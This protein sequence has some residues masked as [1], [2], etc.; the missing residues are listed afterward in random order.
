MATIHERKNKTGQV[1]YT[2]EIR[3]KGHPPQSATFERKT[4]AKLWAQKTEADIRAGKHFGITESKK[5]TV[6]DMVDRYIQDILPHRRSDAANVKRHLEWWKS[7]LGHYRL[8]DLKPPLIAEYRDRLLSE[9]SPKA[10][11]EEEKRSAATVVRYLTSLSVAV[12][13]AVKEWGWMEENPVLKVRKPA[14]PRGRVRFLTDDEREAVLKACK[15]SDSNYLYTIVVLALS[16][17]AR[18]SEILNLQWQHVDLKRKAILLEETKNG[19]RRSLPLSGHGLELVKELRKVPRIDSPYVF[20]RKDGRK[21][22]EIRKKWERAIKE[23]KVKDFRFHDLRHT[24]ASYL[25]MQGASLLEISAVLGHKTLSMVKRYS[26]I[27]EQ[28]TAGILER[29]N[30]LQFEQVAQDGQ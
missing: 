7:K 18:W 9:K 10:K 22:I 12:S 14:E 15:N 11:N 3:I 21:P 1:K 13:Y 4:D 8:S 20:A 26:H 6:A 28:H 16:T 24:C 25:A 17:G 30:S 2:V 5:K 29:M 23:S 27:S 19:E